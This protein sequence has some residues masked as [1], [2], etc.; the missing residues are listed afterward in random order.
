MKKKDIKIVIVGSVGSGKT[1]SV[2][3][4][5]ESPILGTDVRASE[6][7]ALHRKDTT[8]VVMDYGIMHMGNTKLHIYGAPGQRRF[9]FMSSLL[10]VGASGMIIVIDN[11]H[12]APFGELDYYL[13]K[14]GQFLKN[15]PAVI[16]VTHY[17]D[18]TTDTGLVDYHKYCIDKNFDIPVLCLDA[19]KKYQ[20]KK[21]ILYL[22][23]IVLRKSTC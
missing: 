13:E 23:N 19:R 12:S 6:L 10:S 7:Q 4:I 1:T 20:V 22:V 3:A 15:H 21:I 11:G 14:H 17:D 5:S 16:A 2:E 9:D 18:T 8:T